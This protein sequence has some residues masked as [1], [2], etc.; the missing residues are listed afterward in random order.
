MILALFG[1]VHGNL[2]GMYGLCRDWKKETGES[3]DLVLQTGDMG[4]FVRPEQFDR[5][6]RKHFLSDPSELGAA[7]YLDGREPVPIETWFVH[8]N[9]ENFP[10]LKERENAALDPAGR[11]IFLGPGSVR[12]FGSG[13]AALIVASLGGMEYRFG[14]FPAPTQE[15][16]HK[17]LHT[18]SIERLAGARPAVDILL[19]HDAPFNKGLRHR[20][21]TGSPRITRL[22]EILQPRFA[23]YGHYNDPPDA[24]RIG[25]TL[26][27]C[28]NCAAARRI[29]GRDGAMG[30]LRTDTWEFSYVPPYSR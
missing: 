27:A 30:I 26:C 5:A 18:S 29:P 10:L 21:P 12:R 20:F 19:L 24:F 14:K 16:V 8:G 25:G 1:D 6:T 4:L 3:I 2:D 28:L 9:H 22:I 23:F 15:R 7:P 17:Y 13:E 11:L